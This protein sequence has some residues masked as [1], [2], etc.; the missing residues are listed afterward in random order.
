M[1]SATLAPNRDMLGPR[2]SSSGCKA[3]SSASSGAHPHCTARRALQVS[4]SAGDSS[5]P[6]QCR[7]PWIATSTSTTTGVPTRDTGPKA[8]HP[9][10]SFSRAE[11]ELTKDS[12]IRV[13]TPVRDRTPLSLL[14]RGPDVLFPARRLLTW[15]SVMH[16]DSCCVGI[17]ARP[18][19]QDNL[20]LRV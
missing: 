17:M 8:E 20:L 16:Q 2:A 15:W 14:A 19:S 4:S 18:H 13:S 11:A 6:Q 9:A 10:I 1:V 5:A 12:R 7:L 3:R